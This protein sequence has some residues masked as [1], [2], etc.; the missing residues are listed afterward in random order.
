[1]VMKLTFLPLSIINLCLF[2]CLSFGADDKQSENRYQKADF[3]SRGGIGKLYLGRE[4]SQVMGHLGAGWLERPKREQQERTDLLVKGLELK[5][6][7]VVADIGAGS[8]YFSFR[9]AKLVPEGKVHAVDISKQMLAIIRA[10]M[11]KMKV[12]NVVP[13]FSEITDVKLPPDSVDV[14]L[15]VDAYHEFDHPWEMATSILRS[16]KPGGRLVLIEYRME[17]PTVPIKLLHKMTQA[18]AR[19]EM[20]VAGFEWV[21]T[22]DMLPQQHFMV[23]R[24]PLPSKKK[25]KK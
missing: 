21:E 6:T 7:D 16:L 13:V 20:K 10:R 15:I 19:K 11:A 14:A 9:M 12:D 1:M 3:P 17:D 4:I 8:G 5:P 18:Q 2:S 22:K 25:K 24:K 23:F